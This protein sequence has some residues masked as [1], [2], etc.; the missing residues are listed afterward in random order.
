MQAAYPAQLSRVASVR[1]HTALYARPDRVTA[2]AHI[3]KA[4]ATRAQPLGSPQIARM[5]AANAAWIASFAGAGAALWATAPGGWREAA[6]ALWLV[7]EILFW[8]AASF[9]RHPALNAPAPRRADVD[10]VRVAMRRFPSLARSF[11]IK[12]FARGWYLGAPWAALRRGNVEEFASWNLYHRAPADLAAAERA[13]VSEF[14]SGIEAAWGVALPEGHA[15]E[16]GAMRWMW[17][18]L[19]LAHKPLCVYLALE[20]LHRLAGGVLQA[21]GFRRAPVAGGFQ[22]WAAPPLRPAT[23]A[24][25]RAVLQVTPRA[26]APATPLPS[27]PTAP[28][29]PPL[30]RD[31]SARERCR[32]GSGSGSGNSA[33]SL[34]ASSPVHATPP[35]AAG[36]SPF[37]PPPAAASL[38][39]PSPADHPGSAKLPVPVVFLHGVA[40]GGLL[41]YV[42]F[43]RALRAALPA[44]P[45]AALEFPHVALRLAGWAAPDFDA[46]A[47][48]AVVAARRL[49]GGRP[50][51][52][53]GASSRP[54]LR[55]ASARFATSSAPFPPLISTLS[56]AP[57]RSIRTAL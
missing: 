37:A 36:S 34:F 14:V 44:S 30:S 32:R 18:P 55:R 49:G 6:A 29:T 46:V 45:F 41:A 54:F 42:H 51:C 40:P 25:G 38:P 50:A 16:V 57:S 12:D 9:V 2:L 52:F 8:A 19:R 33:A 4:L 28:T 5:T 3:V 17:E 7:A 21:L 15:L 48:A 26:E 11:C 24:A 47:A 1:A 22:V 43:I 56:A 13:E 10:R 20:A 27:P 53:V 35:L 23:A 39:P 31:A